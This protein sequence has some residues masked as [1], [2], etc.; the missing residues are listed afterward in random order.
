MLSPA[1]FP[2]MIVYEP[3]GD[4]QLPRGS[5]IRKRELAAFVA[6]AK[7]LIPLPGAVSVLL[8]G[9]EELRRLNLQFRRK[10]KPTDVLSFPA[11][12]PA[13]L[14][15][16][17]DAAFP[18]GDLAISLETALRQAEAIGH[19][20]EIELKILLLHGLLH[21]AG[22]DHESDTGQ[23]RRKEASLRRKLNLPRSLVERTEPAPA[24]SKGKARASTAA[25]PPRQRPAPAKAART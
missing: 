8:S 9:D 10:N 17:P 7:E 15:M 19:P 23:M 22:F 2:T 6:A 20:L 21:L 16:L 3:S 1:V 5:R 24:T 18:A 14:D 13:A 25:S 4:L 12:F 11:H